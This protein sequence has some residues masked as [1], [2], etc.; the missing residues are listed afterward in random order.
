MAECLPRANCKHGFTCRSINSQTAAV[1]LVSCECGWH[2]G[3][4]C[5]EVHAA[6]PWLSAVRMMLTALT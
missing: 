2:S 4:M 6:E 3:G 1:S 5:N